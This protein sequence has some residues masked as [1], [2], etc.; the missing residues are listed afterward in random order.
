MWRIK[1]PLS[2]GV[3]LLRGEISWGRVVYQS[4]RCLW[5]LLTEYDGSRA[6]FGLARMSLDSRLRIQFC[7][8][9]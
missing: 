5:L 2:K 9:Q 3:C 4:Q 7:G 6:W 1:L 8:R